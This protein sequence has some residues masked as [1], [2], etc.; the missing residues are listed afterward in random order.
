VVKKKRVNRPAPT[1]KGIE[2]WFTRFVKFSADY[3]PH[4]G[5]IH[6]NCR[7][8]MDLY[9]QYL[10]H[11]RGMEMEDRSS[12]SN[13]YKV[14][15]ISMGA[16]IK[17]PAIKLFSR[18]TTCDDFD[19]KIKKTKVKT[20]I[21]YFRVQKELHMVWQMQERMKYYHHVA[22]SRSCPI[23]WCSIISDG[24][25]QS[26]TSL[27]RLKRD[28]SAS[29]KL[30]PLKMAVISVLCHSHKPYCQTFTFPNDFPKDSSMTVEVLV[31][32]LKAIQ[33]TSGLSECLYLQ[34][35]NTVRENKNTT[36]FVFL[37]LLVHF[38]LFQKVWLI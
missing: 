3:I 33:D 26:K 30:N 24:M 34:L 7:H 6:L 22:K 12:S 13:F 23:K 31:R 9:N 16:T 29:A 35:D 37:C 15:A 32:D 2:A 18:C 17:I 25:D 19:D 21:D 11:Q 5:V 20:K 1:K 28:T 36:V 8:K 38:N 14:V 4:L 10:R 27:L